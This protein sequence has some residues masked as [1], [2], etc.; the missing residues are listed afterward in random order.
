MAKRKYRI[1]FKTIIKISQ[2]LIAISA[3]IAP[4]L[5]VL[6]LEIP[7]FVSTAFIAKGLMISVY[8]MILYFLYIQ[9][10]KGDKNEGE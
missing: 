8:V 9:L 4:I 7:D 10:I 6:N 1:D 2:I 3:G 5:W